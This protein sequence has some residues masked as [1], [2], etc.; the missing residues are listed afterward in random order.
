MV[1][2]VLLLC[3]MAVFVS[4]LKSQH[5]IGKTKDQVIKEM[6]T[7]CPDYAMDNS[8]VNYTYKYLKYINKVTEQTLLIFLSE[9]DVCTS[10]KLMSDYSN[11]LL[12][13][14]ELNAKYQPAGKETWTYTLDGVTYK[15]KLK[16]EEWFF[17][18][19]TSK[20]Q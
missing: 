17:T 14:K 15:V 6:K 20:E 9:G 8:S 3:V 16:H 5:F 10:T 18:V 13:K 4:P 11:L 1:Q 19:F 7:T 2:K 12:V